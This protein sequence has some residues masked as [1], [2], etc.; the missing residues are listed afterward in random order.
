MFIVRDLHDFARNRFFPLHV[1]SGTY[2]NF[3]SFYKFMV[4]LFD[5]VDNGSEFVGMG[6]DRLFLCRSGGFFL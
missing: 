2:V 1:G 3:I 5:F 6:F 4:N